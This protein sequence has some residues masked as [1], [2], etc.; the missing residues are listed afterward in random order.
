MGSKWGLLSDPVCL[1]FAV[2][3]L[4]SLHICSLN[5]LQVSLDKASQLFSPAKIGLSQAVEP[6][7]L[8]FTGSTL[9]PCCE[10]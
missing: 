7:R 6:A 5:R 3:I 8:K 4:L 2:A 1:L 10:S 9:L